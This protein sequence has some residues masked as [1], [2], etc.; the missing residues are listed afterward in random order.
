MPA[1]PVFYANLDPASIPDEQGDLSSTSSTKAVL[2]LQALRLLKVPISAGEEFWPRIWLWTSFLHNNHQ[3]PGQPL[4]LDICANFLFIVW[5]LGRHPL[6]FRLV[7]GTPGVR[8]VLVRAWKLLFAAQDGQKP[9]NIA[10]SALFW[11]HREPMDNVDSANFAE[12]IEGAD[13]YARSTIWSN[14]GVL[15][16][17]DALFCVFRGGQDVPLQDVGGVTSFTRL[18]CVFGAS[19]IPQADDI[20]GACLFRLIPSLRKGPLEL[21]RTAREML[22]AGFL[23]AITICGTYRAETALLTNVLIPLLT[24]STTYY[25]VVS[26]FESAVIDAEDLLVDPRFSTSEIFGHW[27]LFRSLAEERVLLWK[28]W[29]SAAYVSQKACDNMDCGH[30]G[31]KADFKSCTCCHTVFYC[32]RRC[33]CLDGNETTA[34]DAPSTEYR[35]PLSSRNISFLQAVLHHDYEAHKETVLRFQLTFMRDHLSESIVTIFDYTTGVVR[36]SVELMNPASS[37]MPNYLGVNCLEH[38]PRALRSAG[39]M[40]LHLVALP[41]GS[42]VMSKFRM[43]PLRSNNSLLYD[44]VCSLAMKKLISSDISVELR[45]LIESARDGLVE[46]H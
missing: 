27:K 25:S 3:S 29:S 13:R 42:G 21:Y 36:I 41:D 1:L 28:F 20:L 12:V 5:N 30:I 37:L 19:R 14:P 17:L 46:I 15:L 44:G 11:V 6:T 43:F 7:S 9:D 38:V 45:K 33:Q 24:Q 8:A 35:D 16:Y 23:R 2:S 31:K 22:S 40:Q 32:S 39:R 10:L 26:Q 34:G 4:E 18:A